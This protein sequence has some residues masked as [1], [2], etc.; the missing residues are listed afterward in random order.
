MNR[1]LY[2]SRDDR[3]IRGVCAGLAEYLGLPTALVRIAFVAL[4]LPGVIHMVI[5]YALLAILIPEAPYQ[6]VASDQ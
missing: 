2:R 1:R 3:M 4:A 5:I 6:R